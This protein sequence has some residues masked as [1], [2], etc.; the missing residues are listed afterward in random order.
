MEIAREVQERLLPQ[1]SPLIPGLDCAGRCRPALGVGGDYYDW[2]DLAGGGLGIA[3]GDVSG[4]GVPAALLMASL[5]AS[6]RSQVTLGGRDLAALMSNINRL[7]YQAT[8]ANRYATFFYAQYQPSSGRID[9]V[10]GG[11]N[12]PMVFR[13]DEVIR[14]DQG[15]QWLFVW[16]SL[17]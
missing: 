13:R 15:G 4:K 12:P 11:H 2:L 10:N 14:L 8:P 3:I 17:L 5:Q 6:L 9:Y 7:I 1:A 16:P